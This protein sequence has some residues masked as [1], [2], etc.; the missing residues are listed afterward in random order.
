[1][2]YVKYEQSIIIRYKVELIGWPALIRFANPS[3]IGTVNE[4]RSLCQALKVRDCK[5]VVQLQWQQVAYAEKLAARAAAGQLVVKK[6]KPRSDKGKARGKKDTSRKGGKC[7]WDGD[8][9]DIRGSEDEQPPVKKQKHAAVAASSTA[10][11]LPPALTSREFSCK[12]DIDGS[13]K[14]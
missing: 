2:S 10:S 4:I 1:M 9:E 13:S 14:D 6:R 3:E 5:W 7:V 11:K 12:G 8:R